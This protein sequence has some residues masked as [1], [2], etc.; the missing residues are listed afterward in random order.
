M[1]LLN[2]TYLSTISP[3]KNKASFS[4]RVGLFILHKA[5]IRVIDFEEKS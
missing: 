3:N 2:Q 5:K 4:V 1:R